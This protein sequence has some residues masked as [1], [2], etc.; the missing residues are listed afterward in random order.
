MTAEQQ[1]ERLI[2]KALSYGYHVHLDETRGVPSMGYGT[3]FRQTHKPIIEMFTE[4]FVNDIIEAYKS[5]LRKAIEEKFA[6]DAILMQKIRESF[7]E[8]MDTVTP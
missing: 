4:T 5:A 7:F 8:L 1:L 2:S 6:G 3:R